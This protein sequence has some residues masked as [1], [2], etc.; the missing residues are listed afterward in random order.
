MD[1][2]FWQDV[3]QAAAMVDRGTT[4][5]I[6]GECSGRAFKV[7]GV[8]GQIRIDIPTTQSKE[9]TDVGSRVH[10]GQRDQA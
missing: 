8:P 6:D 7:Y 3:S 10:E 5:R 4:R 1:D 2:A 9:V